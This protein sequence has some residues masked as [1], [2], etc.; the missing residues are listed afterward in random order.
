MGIGHLMWFCKRVTDVTL[1]PR[2]DRASKIDS[3][4]IETGRFLIIKDSCLSKGN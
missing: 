2:S 1:K 3:S 4:V